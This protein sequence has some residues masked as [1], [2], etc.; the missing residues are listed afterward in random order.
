MANET[1]RAG[2]LSDVEPR[3]SSATV[4]AGDCIV[5]MDGY[6]RPQSRT[7][8]LVNEKGR[9]IT[10]LNLERNIESHVGQQLDEPALPELELIHHQSKLNQALHGVSVPRK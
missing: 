6:S 9:E 5:N 1:N 7:N 10:T 4:T 3:R 8:T 2:V